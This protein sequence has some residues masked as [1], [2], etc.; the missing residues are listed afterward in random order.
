MYHF[1]PQPSIESINENL[2]DNLF[3]SFSKKLPE[4]AVTLSQLREQI[5]S[6]NQVHGEI[7]KMILFVLGACFMS[8]TIYTSII[9]FLGLFR[10][11]IG[12]SILMGCSSIAMFYGSAFFIGRFLSN[13]KIFPHEKEEDISS[14]LFKQFN[15]IDSTLILNE[16]KDT[17][18]QSLEKTQIQK[19]NLAVY[20]FIKEGIHRLDGDFSKLKY[21]IDSSEKRQKF[22]FDPFRNFFAVVSELES[23]IES[24]KSIKVINE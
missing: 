24:A 16:L 9:A 22:S 19:Y 7:I 3:E 13:R 15:A 12:I 2:D 4:P 14:N 8:T 23:A 18:S 21:E 17:L 10:I 6:K 1:K 5:T 20:D 11:N